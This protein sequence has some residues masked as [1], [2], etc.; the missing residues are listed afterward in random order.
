VTRDEALLMSGRAL[1]FADGLDDA[2]IGVG[3]RCGQPDI[4]VY[5]YDQC[6]GVFMGQG[7]SLD[8]AGEYMEFNVVGA[9]VGPE[10][11]MFVHAITGED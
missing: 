10:T 8:E 9:W 6:V 3:R 4:T 7:M 2:L 5:D 11:P 1:T